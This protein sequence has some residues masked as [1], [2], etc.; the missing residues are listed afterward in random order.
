[1]P[2]HHHR[3]DAAASP[4][5]RVLRIVQPS[6]GRGLRCLSGRRAIGSACIPLVKAGGAYEVESMPED[7]FAKACEFNARIVRVKPQPARFEGVCDGEAFTS[8][9]D[10]AVLYA[11]GTRS[12]AVG[13]N[14]VED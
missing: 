6:N 7:R 5:D 4:H 14:E 11:D 9:L 12:S 1:M 2:T 13:L 10:A 8:I 3:P